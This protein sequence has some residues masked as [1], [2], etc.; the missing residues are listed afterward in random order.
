MSP[1]VL[2]E[3]AAKRGVSLL[4]LTDHN[5]ALNSP[6]FK[7]A[8]LNAGIIPL[9]GLEAN[10]R[11]EVHVVCLFGTLE[12]ALDFSEFIYEHVPYFKNQPERLGDQV[13][14]DED[15]VIIGEVER[16][17]GNCLDISVDD[18]GFHV[19]RFGG[20]S[21]PAHIDRPMYSM[22]SQLGF[23]VKGPWS[24]LECLKIPPK[25]DTLGY[26]LTTSS[27]A[28]TPEHI[29]RR[30]FE[31]DAELQNLVPDG[32][33]RGVDIGALKMALARRRRV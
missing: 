26:P 31:L 2:A 10:T 15:E 18:I 29:A 4:A 8:C 7:S 23:V 33:A 9:F 28:H 5:S 30:A 19:D 27:D 32:A 17:L 24:A 6:A 16:Y 3:T 12:A 13:Y 21:I 25:L 20:L 14:V 22:A 11:E 1:R